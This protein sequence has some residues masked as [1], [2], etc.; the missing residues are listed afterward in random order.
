MFATHDFRTITE[1]TL[2]HLQTAAL[3]PG[4][5][6]QI[7]LG[8]RVTLRPFQDLGP[9]KALDD[10]RTFLVSSTGILSEFVF[11]WKGFEL[12]IEPS[13]KYTFSVAEGDRF[14]EDFADLVL[15]ADVRRLL[16]FDVGD[17]TPVLGVYA[18]YTNYFDD[19]VFGVPNGETV[20]LTQQFDVGVAADFAPRIKVWFFRIPRVSVGWAWG[21][22]GSGV[23]IRF[24]D[25]VTHLPD[26]DP[27]R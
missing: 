5:E 24:G 6:F 11:P 7:P 20:R 16:W 10:G 21:D 22:N 2:D 13:L 23:R 8:E 18:G 27:T 1:I 14:D 15:G 12:G 4:L 17:Y 19:L 25:R 9:G 26:Y 3:V